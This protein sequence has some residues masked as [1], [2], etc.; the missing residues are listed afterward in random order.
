MHPLTYRPERACRNLGE[1]AQDE[2]Q[3]VGS[4]H[5][6]IYCRSYSGCAYF[7]STLNKLQRGSGLDSATLFTVLECRKNYRTFPGIKARRS[8]C[9]WG[10]LLNME[11]CHTRVVVVGGWHS[12]DWHE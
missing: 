8:T 11:I 7:W 3:W 4:E 10:P 6:V 5:I 1:Q 12:N 9:W 2:W